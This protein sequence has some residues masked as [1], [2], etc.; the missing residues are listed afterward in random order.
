LHTQSFIHMG[1]GNC[2]VAKQL[3]GVANDYAIRR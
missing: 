1:M 2:E 3:K